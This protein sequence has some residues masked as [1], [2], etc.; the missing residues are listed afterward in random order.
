MDY[1]FENLNPEKFQEFAQAL[2][3]REFTDLQCFPVAQ[4]DGGRD[5]VTYS[6]RLPSQNF[7]IYQVKYVRKPLAEKDIHKWLLRIIKGEA[8]KVKK[9][10][11]KGPND[12]FSLQ[13][14]QEQRILTLVQLIG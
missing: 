8:P 12:F 4:S 10:I 11:E 1:P 14:F 5:I 2:L 7:A 6:H 9:L 13:M 3:G